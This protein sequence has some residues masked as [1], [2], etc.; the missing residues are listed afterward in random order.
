VTFDNTLL[1]IILSFRELTRGRVRFLRNKLQHKRSSSY[2]YFYE[3]KHLFFAYLKANFH[4]CNL[5]IT[6]DLHEIL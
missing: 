5:F 3:R 2:Y 4:S 6:R 1:I